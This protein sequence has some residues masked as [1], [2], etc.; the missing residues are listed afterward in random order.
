[1]GKTILRSTQFKKDFKRIQHDT[2]KVEALYRVV[3]HLETGLPI[4]EEYQPH[5][6]K[7]DLRGIWECHVLNDL[8]LLW[9]D[10]DLN[11]VRLLRLGSH[12]ETLGL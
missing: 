5:I 7:G 10:E 8:L 12:S 4:P 1:M 6:L 9:I 3:K 2:A 11:I